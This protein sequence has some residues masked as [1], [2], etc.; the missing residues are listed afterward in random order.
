MTSPSVLI[1]GATGYT[2]QLVAA[3]AK[4]LGLPVVI[5]GR[6]LGKTKS[7]AEKLG[8]PW[9]AFAL[10]DTQRLDAAVAAAHTVLHLAGPF[11]ATAQPMVEACL[12]H[13]RHYLDITGEI[14]VFEYCASRGAEARAKGIMLMPGVGF[15][16]V[17]SDCM[18]Q[19][20]RTRLPD[21]RRLTLAISGMGKASRGTAKTMVESL[22]QGTKVRR[23]GQIVALPRAPMRNVDFGDG[24][25]PCVGV[26]WGDVA[27]AW[28]ATA[29]PDIEVYFEA[30]GPVKRLASMGA[31]MRWLGR[32]RWVQSLL[33]RQIDRM[34]EGPTPEERANTTHIIVAEASNA[35]GR[36]VTSRLRTMEGY[37]LTRETAV[38]IAARVLSGQFKPGFQTP[39][40]AFG[41]D[42]VLGFAKSERIDL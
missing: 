12:R 21:A 38:A 17:P 31:L 39:S 30:Q 24:P 9:A 18:A 27:T 14:D 15:D 29:I 32:Q 19:H 33:K 6:N 11:S 2:G 36:T 35:S 34:P 8:L 22:G 41:A 40:L 10:T 7:L 42:F 25:K 13:G 5:A 3:H 1:Y 26:S 23:G 37:S 16:V 28:H 20:M 4:D